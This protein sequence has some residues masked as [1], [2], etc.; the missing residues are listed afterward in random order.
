[1]NGLSVSLDP[2]WDDELIHS[3]GLV[4]ACQGVDLF[5]PNLAE[6]RAITRQDTPEDVLTALAPHFPIVAPETG[7]GGRHARP[8]GQG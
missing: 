1:M 8:P 2:S 5:L 6:G 4:D 7:A 3:P